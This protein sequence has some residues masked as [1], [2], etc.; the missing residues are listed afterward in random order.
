[1]L[2]LGK[3][4]KDPVKASVAAQAASAVLAAEA[5]E[6]KTKV[7]SKK[8]DEI[9]LDDLNETTLMKYPIVAK[10]LDDDAMVKLKPKDSSKTLRWC[11]FANGPVL[12]PNAQKINAVNISRYKRRGF[13]FATIEDIE[14][15]EDALTEGIIDD[16]G[17]IINYDTVLMIIDK[18]RLM[19]HYKQGLQ[20][21][22]S[23]VDNAL[24]RAI[25]GAESELHSTNDYRKAMNTH[26]QAKIEFYSPAEK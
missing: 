6:L 4:V 5:P 19:G 16:G 9:N 11:Y 3:D 13:D 26:P 24:G 1:M 17:R 22:M 14:G 20:K 12:S 10:S 18:I 7:T 23:M 2:N 8:A 25:K 15:G 21:S